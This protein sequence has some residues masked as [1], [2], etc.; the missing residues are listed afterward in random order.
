[1]IR[2]LFEVAIDRAALIAYRYS[3][4]NVIENEV[5]DRCDEQ[6]QKISVIAQQDSNGKNANAQSRV[7]IFLQIE[8]IIAAHGAD[9]DLAGTPQVF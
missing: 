9:I 3:F 4:Q 6:T 1:M 8:A 7:E 5:D 2:M